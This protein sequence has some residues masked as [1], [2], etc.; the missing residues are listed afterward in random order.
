MECHSK[1]KIGAV[2]YICCG[3]VLFC[4]EKKLLRIFRITL[5]KMWMKFSGLSYFCLLIAWAAGSS[6]YLLGINGWC[7][8]I[9][10]YLEEIEWGLP[11][12]PLLFFFLF[13]DTWIHSPSSYLHN[14]HSAFCSNIFFSGL[15]SHHSW[16]DCFPV[17]ETLFP[18]NVFLLHIPFFRQGAESFTKAAEKACGRWGTQLQC[19]P[20]SYTNLD[21]TWWGVP[22]PPLAALAKLPQWSM[23]WILQHNPWILQLWVLLWTLPRMP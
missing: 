12:L 18:T 1:G 8:F 21:G 13:E 19:W 23:A 4:P 15:Y 17:M 7:I 22:L 3:V 2:M 16:P 6:F 20:W 14:F 11:H 10:F 9:L 5:N